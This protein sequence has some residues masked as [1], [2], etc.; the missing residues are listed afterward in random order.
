VDGKAL[1]QRII[2]PLHKAIKAMTDRVA[3]KFDQ[4][5]HNLKNKV[6]MRSTPVL[7]DLHSY[8]MIYTGGMWRTP[9][10]WGFNS[11]KADDD[12]QKGKAHF[13]ASVSHASKM[14][15]CVIHH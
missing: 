14:L 10:S 4:D 2:K 8:H 9:I 12:G 13:A 5:L 1:I 7:L 6:R 15:S 3:G 11:S